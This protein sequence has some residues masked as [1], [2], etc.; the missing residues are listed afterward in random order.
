MSIILNNEL[1]VYKL[2]LSRKLTRKLVQ[3]IEVQTAAKYPL[4]PKVADFA[5][6]ISCII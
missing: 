2:F 1:F 4:P 6:R 3:T 5:K